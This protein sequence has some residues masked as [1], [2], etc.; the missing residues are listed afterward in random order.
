MDH[1]DFGGHRRVAEH[2]SFATGLAA[3]KTADTATGIGAGG[4]C[5]IRTGG[6][7][8]QRQNTPLA[9]QVDRPAHAVD[10]AHVLLGVDALDFVIDL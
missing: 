7:R 5:A 6:P 10:H 1:V 9:G 8:R 4:G 3:P 2:Q